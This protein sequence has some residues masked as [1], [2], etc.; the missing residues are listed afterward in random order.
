VGVATF[1][2][3]G[4]T[5]IDAHGFPDAVRGVYIAPTFPGGEQNTTGWAD[6]CGSSFAA[7]IISALG[8]HLF[9]QGWSAQ[10][11]MTRIVSGQERRSKQLFGA[12]P[13]VPPLLA[14]IVRVQQRFFTAGTSRP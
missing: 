9:V 11:I 3:D 6:W 5:S 8:A 12:R 1:G 13:D 10:H 4:A 7:P 14:N 2:G